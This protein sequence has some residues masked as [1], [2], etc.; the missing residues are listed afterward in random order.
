M[1]V[2]SASTAFIGPRTTSLAPRRGLARNPHFARILF[3]GW[4]IAKQNK[5]KQTFTTCQADGCALA[6]SKVQVECDICR[7]CS[8]Q[9]T[10]STEALWVSDL[11]DR[12]WSQTSQ[13]PKVV[14]DPAFCRKPAAKFMLLAKTHSTAMR[15]WTTSSEPLIS[16]WG[17]LVWYYVVLNVWDC[18]VRQVRGAAAKTEKARRNMSQLRHGHL[19]RSTGAAPSAEK[20]AKDQAHLQLMLA[21]AWFG[22]MCRQEIHGNSACVWFGHC[23]SCGD[24]WELWFWVLVLLT[25]AL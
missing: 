25:V 22:S 20:A 8:I 9:D 5:R 15:P 14:T 17:S 10:W 2:P 4:F 7:A 13:C 1:R 11:G 19:R 3:A 12:M 18:V 23:A 24:A 6:Y 21:T 16:N